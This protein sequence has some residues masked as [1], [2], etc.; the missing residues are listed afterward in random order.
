MSSCQRAPSHYLNWYWLIISHVLWH[1]P[2]GNFTRNAEDIYPWYIFENYYFNIRALS[3]RGGCVNN[4]HGYIRLHKKYSSYLLPDNAFLSCYIPMN[5][6]LRNH[7]WASG[8]SKNSHSPTIEVRN[9]KS[10]VLLSSGQQS[11]SSSSCVTQ[12]SARC[13]QWRGESFQPRINST[14][15]C[16]QCV[17]RLSW[18][19]FMFDILVMT[20]WLANWPH[21]WLVKGFPGILE[22][23]I[24]NWH[25]S[26]EAISS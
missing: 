13:K 9:I 2:K 4:Q 8:N 11:L 26:H 17:I 22:L 5:T 20:K 19:Q 18:C 15:C 24:Q 16:G 14:H 12:W 21:Q 1:S 7:G 25:P 6:V 10:K 3:L 23:S